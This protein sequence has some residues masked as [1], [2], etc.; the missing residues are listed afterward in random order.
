MTNTPRRRDPQAGSVKPRNPTAIAGSIEQSVHCGDRRTAS[1]SEGPQ[2]VRRI[3][4]AVLAAKQQRSACVH[5]LENLGAH[6]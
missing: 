4:C 1:K 6:H 3:R 5:T 2:V